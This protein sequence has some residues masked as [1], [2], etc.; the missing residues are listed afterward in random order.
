LSRRQS[1][2]L[3][4]VVVLAVGLAGVGL[5]QVAARQGLWA[6]TFEVTVAVPEA[7]DVG[8]GTPVR[9]R[10]VDAGQVVAVE[11]PDHDGPDAAV[12]L[13][14]RV[15]GKFAGRLYADASA[16]VLPTG[17]LGSKVISIRPGSPARGPLADGRLKAEDS[18][19]FA[20]TAAQLGD[21]T[22]K[23]TQTADKIGATADETKQLVHD[24]RTSDGTFAKLV[25]DDELYQDLKGLAKDSRSMVQ[26][27]D[28][29]V[30][31]VE[32]EVQKVDQFVADG[33]DTLRSVKQGTDA[34][35]K[36]PI[37]R[38]YVEDSAALLVRPTCRREQYPFHAVHL[39]EPN[40]ALLTDD[41]R[42]HLTRVADVVKATAVDE[43]DVVVVA[44]CDPTDK[45][46]TSASA[47]ELTKKQSEAVVEFLKAHGVH[48]IG[49][50]SRRKMTP[51][52]LGFGPS[53][54]VEKE[55]LPPSSL[56]VLVFTPQ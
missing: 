25:K 39:F 55:P 14:L 20:K 13:R 2:V 29:A 11:Y 49:W 36:L 34:L 3:G 33:R 50:V 47:G 51:L 12:T 35:Q 17:L 44:Q 28:A 15:D 43:A 9:V 40:T 8:P 45:T 16:Q 31:K 19:D 4:L 42:T 46:Q 5:T 48:K 21:A 41:G 54:V 30:G 52:G 1:V 32:G 53:P 18:P 27:A 10:G 7:H 22:K 24:V 38:S 26:R 56:Q 23:L 37:V 6:D